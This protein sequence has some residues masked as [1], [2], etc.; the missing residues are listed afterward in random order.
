[1]L[2]EIARPV[3]EAS[4]IQPQDTVIPFRFFDLPPELRILIYEH[5]K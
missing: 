5:R 3:S 1:M 4:D 2:G